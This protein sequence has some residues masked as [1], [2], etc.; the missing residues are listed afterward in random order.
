MSAT[1]D[2]ERGR[3]DYHETTEH[4]SAIKAG[5]NFSIDAGG[6]AHLVGT[7]VD[8]DT[9]TLKTGGNLT[10]ESAQH[11]VKDDSYD[12]SGHV[13]ASASKGGGT[14]GAAGV[15]HGTSGTTK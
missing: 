14:G 5:G 3:T 7:Q 2:F 11:I 12:V 10:I 15:S 4:G 8:A 9:A 6:N 13:E 1:A